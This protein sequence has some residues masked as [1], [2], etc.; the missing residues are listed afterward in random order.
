MCYDVR[1]GAAAALLGSIFMTLP[2][3][4][5]TRSAKPGPSPDEVLLYSLWGEPPL[6]EIA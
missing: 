2:G 3:L 1:T 4:P 5:A 6:P